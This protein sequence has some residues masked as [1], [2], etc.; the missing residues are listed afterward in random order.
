MARNS[1]WKHRGTKPLRIPQV[2]HEAGG[3]LFKGLDTFVAESEEQSASFESTFPVCKEGED[4]PHYYRIELIVTHLEAPPAISE[5]APDPA[6]DSEPELVESPSDVATDFSPE[7]IELLA[8]AAE[9]V[10]EAV[11]EPATEPESPFSPEEIE[12]LAMA[13]EAAEAT[14]PATE[15]AT[16][17]FSP[18]EIEWLATLATAAK[19]VPEPATEPASQF[20]PEEIEW[21]AMASEDVSSMFPK[22]AIA[23]PTGN[24]IAN[25]TEVKAEA[26]VNISSDFV[27]VVEQPQERPK[28]EGVALPALDLTAFGDQVYNCWHRL[29]ENEQL[30]VWGKAV[31]L[32]DIY[33]Y[34]FGTMPGSL[35]LTYLQKLIEQESVQKVA[36]IGLVNIPGKQNFPVGDQSVCA[37]TFWS[38]WH[39]PIAEVN[40]QPAKILPRSTALLIAI[41]QQ[42]QLD[43]VRLNAEQEPIA[44]NSASS[45]TTAQNSAQNSAQN[46]EGEMFGDRNQAQPHLIAQI[47]ELDPLPTVVGQTPEYAQQIHPTPATPTSTLDRLRAERQQHLQEI[48]H[49]D[50]VQNG[51]HFVQ[52]SRKSAKP[53]QGGLVEGFLGL[54][55]KATS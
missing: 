49:P 4:C 10:P 12:L 7:E 27:M 3:E 55:Q 37:L 48:G 29:A 26:T 30:P 32:D 16:T 20:S 24:T 22:E 8:M 19:A 1:S 53:A 2:F 54:F 6:I 31:E 18:E 52:N 40:D 34:A 38:D 14:E 47:P 43:A 28:P 11:T 17:D 42:Q 33:R 5:I 35:F 9:A 25:E 13:A 23:K 44:Q 50:S 39:L 51:K 36:R 15:P 41:Q 21:L 46:L 45:V